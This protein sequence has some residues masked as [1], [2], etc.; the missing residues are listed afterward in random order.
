ML[1]VLVRAVRVH[2]EPDTLYLDN[3]ST[4]RGDTLRTACSRLGIARF[5]T[6]PYDPAAKGKMER[7][8]RRLREQRL[9]H[10]RPWLEVDGKCFPCHPVDP[11]RNAHRERPPRREPHA[12]PTTPSDSTVVRLERASREFLVARRWRTE[13]GTTSGPPLP[14]VSAVTPPPK[15][16]V[17]EEPRSERGGQNERLG[18]LSRT[19]PDEKREHG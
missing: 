3:G 8:W 14:S 4:Y 11:E 17:H 13:S 1:G 12:A 16:G 10:H 15:D 19:S 9:D 2:G 5:H 7:F 18:P 6:R